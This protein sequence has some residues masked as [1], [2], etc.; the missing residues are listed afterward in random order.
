VGII[1]TARGIVATCDHCRN[2]IVPETSAFQVLP[3][4]DSSGA[5]KT[6]SNEVTLPIRLACSIPCRDVLMAQS[7]EGQATAVWAPFSIAVLLAHLE[8]DSGQQ[9]ASER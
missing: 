9:D 8:E 6:G 2:T 7:N 1:E 5:L 3:H 4:P